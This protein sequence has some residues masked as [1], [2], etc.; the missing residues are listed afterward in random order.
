TSTGDFAFSAESGTVWMY[1]SEWYDSGQLVPDQ[2][3]PASDELPI[4]N[5]TKFIKTGGTATEI[6]L[7]NG[8]TTTIDSHLSRTY[9]SGTGGYIR[10]C[11]FPSG[12]STRMPYIQFQVTCNTNAM[13]TID[14]VPNYSVNGISALYGVFTAPSYVQTIYNVYY[15]VDQLLHTHT[16]TGSSAVYTA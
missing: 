12:G 15:G 16:G 9:S 7:A 4:I 5:A 11:V 10:L 2:V 8:D 6:L 1:E 3:T 13:Q 14:L